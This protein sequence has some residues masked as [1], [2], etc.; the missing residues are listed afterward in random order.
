MRHLIV[1][2]LFSIKIFCTILLIAVATN[3]HA[4]S[5][6]QTTADSKLR[7]GPSVK[8]KTLGIIKNGEKVNVIER[9][10]SYWFKIEH[11]GKTGFVSIKLL[12]P[13]VEIQ[14]VEETPKIE[15]KIPK[16]NSTLPYVIGGAT[17]VLLLVIF[18]S[19]NKNNSIKLIKY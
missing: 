14:K 3:L 4:Q 5:Y 2:R 19:R 11:N 8:Y 12:K 16:S 10:N 17:L 13:I 7:S 18:A 9:I 6:Y 15:K 1:N